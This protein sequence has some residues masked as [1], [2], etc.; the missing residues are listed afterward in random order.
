MFSWSSLPLT[1]HFLCVVDSSLE[2]CL[3]SVCILLPGIKESKIKI[4]RI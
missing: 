1:V 4:K 3:S 2:K